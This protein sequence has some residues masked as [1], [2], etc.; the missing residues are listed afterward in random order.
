MNRWMEDAGR[1][2]GVS[3]KQ[4]RVS[5]AL[6]WRTWEEGVKALPAARREGVREGP[7]LR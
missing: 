3:P 2:W 7:L 4:G 5:Q 1:H 6:V